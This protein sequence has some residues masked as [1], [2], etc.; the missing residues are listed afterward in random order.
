MI[1]MLESAIKSLLTYGDA[2]RFLRQGLFRNRFVG[3][4][5]LAYLDIAGRGGGSVTSL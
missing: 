2:L 3:V 4:S 5:A 1:L